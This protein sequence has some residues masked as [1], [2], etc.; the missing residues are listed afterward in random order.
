MG[1]E[2]FNADPNNNNNQEYPE[3][4]P[5]NVGKDIQPANDDPVHKG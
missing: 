1:G 2:H 5:Y 3:E 4:I